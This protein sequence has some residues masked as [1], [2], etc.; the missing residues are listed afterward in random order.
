[1][2][3]KL[4][5]KISSIQNSIHNKGT[6]SYESMADLFTLLSFVLII[7]TF[8]FGV[9][10]PTNNI[11]E[12]IEM[13]LQEITATGNA[14]T[15]IPDDEIFFIL[16]KKQ[17]MDY[18]YFYKNGN[19]D[20][21]FYPTTDNLQSFLKKELTSIQKAEKVSLILHK[22]NGSPNNNLFVQIQEFL[23]KN[24]IRDAKLFF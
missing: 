20:N 22:K 12:N 19:L 2:N 1:M 14:D 10:K 21:K 15:F 8:I 3:I 11:A 13:E 23:A 18:I 24:N 4:I 6:D 9:N 17:K 7:I 5:N 16:T